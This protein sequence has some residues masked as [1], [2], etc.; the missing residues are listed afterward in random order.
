MKGFL[1]FILSAGVFASLIS[2]SWA[3]LSV[4]VVIG[5]D[6]GNYPFM[7]DQG[8]K[9][10]G[11]YPA[12]VSAA[13]ERMGVSL[14]ESVKPWARVLAEAETGGAGVGGLYKNSEREKK[15]DFS[16][17]IYEEKILVYVSDNQKFVYNTID[18]LNDKT[19][20]VMHGWSYGDAFDRA[21]AAHK[22]RVEEVNNDEQNLQKLMAGRVDAVLG[23]V[24]SLDDSI[25]KLVRANKVVALKKPLTV[26]NT[27][28]AFPKLTNQKDLLKRFDA[29]IASMK[30]DGTYDAAVKK[31]LGQE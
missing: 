14:S 19:I 30:T 10:A 3:Q 12:L 29:A 28:I 11:I 25:A 18:D 26:N 8:G 15:Y 22:F 6:E 23:A 31:G 1:R 17:P 13:F 4:P 20:G 24:Q 16:S 5:F 7:Y 9:P 2:T 27:Y 21:K